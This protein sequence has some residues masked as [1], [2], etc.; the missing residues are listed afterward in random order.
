VQSNDNIGAL[1]SE[2]EPWRDN[3]KIKEYLIDNKHI[4][5]SLLVKEKGQVKPH[6]RSLSPILSSPVCLL[7]PGDN[8]PVM[9]L[10]LIL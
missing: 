2:F 6:L 7:T 9:A 8:R 3:D 10:P 1:F 5:S 4:L